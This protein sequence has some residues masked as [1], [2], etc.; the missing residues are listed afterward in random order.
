M[1]NIRVLRF[2][3]MLLDPFVLGVC[4]L[5]FAGTTINTVHALVPSQGGELQK[6]AQQLQHHEYEPSGTLSFCRSSIV[7]T[8]PWASSAGFDYESRGGSQ[9]DRRGERV[10]HSTSGSRPIHP[11]SYRN[12]RRELRRG[13]AEFLA[14]DDDR[15]CVISFH[16]SWC[17]SCQKFGLLY[18]SLAHKLGDKRDRKTQNIVERGSVR[19]ASVE[20]GANTALCRSLG[21]KRL[22][23]TQ[24]YH[25]G[26]LLTS[27]A[28][29]PAKFQTLKDQIKYMTRT[30]QNSD[31]LAAIKAN[32]LFPDEQAVQDKVQALLAAHTEQ[33]FSKT[34]DIGAALIDATVMVAPP[35]SDQSDGSNTE[36]HGQGLSRAERMAA[37]AERIRSKQN[38]ADHVAT[39]AESVAD[40]SH[41]VWWR[42]RRAP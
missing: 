29:A 41:K 24:I 19:F 17:K 18:K 40:S 42:F 14:L 28:C 12:R 15:L 5:A 8:H 2:R 27:F 21:I 9:D 31:R 30:L 16:A 11:D 32:P 33:E 37:F 22:P 25:A 39:T 13:L 23:T 26:T 10:V 7:V 35:S 34:L 3:Q 38:R 4:L 36:D 1:T 20:W 6:A